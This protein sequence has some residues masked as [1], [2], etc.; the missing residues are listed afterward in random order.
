MFNKIINLILKNSFLLERVFFI[1]KIL[2]NNTINKVLFTNWFFY[3][4]YLL[5]ILIFT[6]FL[7]SCGSSKIIKEENNIQVI[8]ENI[9]QTIK[10]ETKIT[11][12]FLLDNYSLEFHEI[13]LTN[14]NLTQVP[15]FE[16]FL[17][18]SYIDDVW[19]INL[20]NNKIKN[21][22]WEYFKYFPNLKELNLS[23]NEIEN[24]EL[25]HSFLQEL[26]LHKNKLK[27]VNLEWSDKINM[28]NLWY[29]EFKTLK[30]TKLPNS[31][32]TL[33]LQHNLLE[34][35]SWL[36]KLIDLEILKLEFNN[37]E[38]ID[39]WI[40]KNL[41]NLNNI[42][43]SKNKLSEKLEKWFINFNMK[44]SKKKE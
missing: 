28:L 37:L 26:K 11:L 41:K 9:T 8:K 3:M 24:F 20:S 13:N 27:N 2:K 43:V 1:E 44:M 14:Q 38:D 23:Y 40:L 22:D 19:Y 30:D 12:E 25:G 5:L 16:K 33:E 15:N 6:L 39:M 4:K 42:T 32:K 17:T 21:I 31:I 36:D 7:T 34:D 18:W 10:E 35:I 29:N